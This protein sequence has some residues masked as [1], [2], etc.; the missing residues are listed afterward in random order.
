M[1]GGA[2]GRGRFRTAT[3]EAFFDAL[4]N[5]DP[6]Y[7][8]MPS[9]IKSQLWKEDKDSQEVPEYLRKL[10]N[11]Y[12]PRLT[13]MADA[14]G[15]RGYGALHGWIGCSIAARGGGRT[16]YLL[17]NSHVLAEHYHLG[18]KRDDS[19]IMLPPPTNAYDFYFCMKMGAP[20]PEFSEYLRDA[21]G[22]STLRAPAIF[23]IC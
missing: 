6:D 14:T 4:E 3:S 19:W 21:L 8:F 7:I 12:R 16:G 17:P 22:A 5:F 13:A 10:Y 18:L 11:Q 9:G 20:C 2:R 1:L 23:W 15:V